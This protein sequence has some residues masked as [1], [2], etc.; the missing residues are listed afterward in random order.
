MIRGS[1]GFRTKSGET[2]I[3][4]AFNSIKYK[5]PEGVREERRECQVETA[6][7]ASS[8]RSPAE[9]DEDIAAVSLHLRHVSQGD[10][11]LGDAKKRFGDHHLVGWLALPLQRLRP[12]LPTGDDQRDF[13]THHRDGYIDVQSRGNFATNRRPSGIIIYVKQKWKQDPSSSCSRGFTL[14]CEWSCRTRV[15]RTGNCRDIR[16]NDSL[17][18]EIDPTFLRTAVKSIRWVS[19]RLF[20]LTDL[21]SLSPPRLIK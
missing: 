20:T 13:R 17:A 14:L 16:P 18:W 9:R 3:R 21:L 12:R 6:R 11:R 4:G 8:A 7:R 15:S 10:A 1:R 19:I 2:P 5:F